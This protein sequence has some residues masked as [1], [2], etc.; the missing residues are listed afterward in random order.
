MRSTSTNFRRLALAIAGVLWFTGTASAAEVRVMI[1]GGLPRR[2]RAAYLAID[3]V[4]ARGSRR[5]AAWSTRGRR[6]RSTTARSSRS[7]SS[8]P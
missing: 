2:L 8:R 1:S 4:V 3:D 5:R 6:R 7:S